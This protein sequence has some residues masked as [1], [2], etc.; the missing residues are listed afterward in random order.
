MITKL[1]RASVSNRGL[2]LLLALMLAGASVY[3][4]THIPL[5]ALP[6]VTPVQVI[7]HT[8]WTGQAPQV[9]EDQ[10][11]FPLTTAMLSV[12]KSTEVRGYSYFG[13]S[14]VFVTFQDGT[15]PY[16]ARSRV[17][18]YLSQIEGRLPE[19][20]KPA[21]G[22]DATSVG[23]VYQYALVDRT[24]QHSLAQLTSIQDWYL[25][26]ALQSVPGVAEVATMGGMVKQYQVVLD[27]QKL[28]AYDITLAKVKQA[29][30]NSS[31][32]VGG[33]VIEMAEAEYMVRATG[34]I[35]SIQDLKHIP[36]TLGKN[37]T[38]VL[39]KSV[40]NIRLGPAPRRGV[41]DLNGNGEV[42]GGIVIMRYDQNALKVIGAVK[43]KLDKLSKSL[44]PGVEIMPTYDRSTLIHH[45]VN[46][47][48]HRL[49]EEIVIVLLVCVL[50]LFH[51]RSA[52]VLVVSLPLGVLA[53]FVIMYWQGIHANI[54]SLGGLALAIGAMVDPAI[55]MIENLH[56]HFER[57]TPNWDNRW[58]IVTQAAT[59]VGPSLFFSLVI[60]A[61]SFL[62]VF[63]LQGQ[64]GRMFAPLAYTKTYA[65]AAAAGLAVTLVPVLMGYFVRGRIIPER[66]NPINRALIAAYR[67][68]IRLVLRWPR[69]VIGVAVVIVALAVIPALKLGSEFMP[70][71]REGTLLYMPITYP[72]V[73][74]GEASQILQITDKLISTVPEVKRVFGKVGRARTAT[75]T[76]PIT[77][78]DTVVMLK[79]KPQWRP[80][81]TIEKLKRKLDELVDL[82]GLSNAWV[83]PIQTRQRMAS[84]G[85]K[86][87]VGIRI[88]GP[89]LRTIERIGE[90]VQAVM[91]QVPGT[92]SAFAE[93]TASGRYI[94]VDIQRQAAARFGLTIAD[95]QGVVA[96]AVGGKTLTTTV[97]G[98]ERY[99]V[100]IRYPQTYRD[101]PESLSML[102]LVTPSGARITLGRVAELRI[103]TGPSMITTINARPTGTVYVDFADRDLGAYVADARKA[104]AAKVDLPTG[105]TITWAGR[106][107]NLQQAR[108]RL[109]VVVPA[110]LL[111]IV[112]LL[113]LNFRRFAEV[114]MIMGTLP[115]AL[116]GGFVL[117]WLLDYNLSVAAWVGFIALGGVAAELGVIM[118]LY[119]NQAWQARLERA[120]GNNAKP[121]LQDLHEAVMEG[122]ALRIRP[123]A[124][125][126]AA[127][128][129]GLLPIMIGGGTGSAIMRS[130]AAPMVGGMVTAT[131]LSLLV[132]PAVYYLWQRRLLRSSLSVH[133]PSRQG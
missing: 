69:A 61:L 72:S 85:I 46:T 33:N 91:R 93:R 88:S 4:I 121:C 115:L 11:T 113:Y 110:T 92:V 98:R 133:R 9:I 40:A 96:T 10:V 126:V 58:R 67:P 118:L 124:M 36:L 37:G 111:I 79:P 17:L 73:S 102:P 129:A 19:G 114:W 104:V 47:L 89:D 50:F 65:M 38:P 18:E 76:A 24:G 131:L 25:K 109:M 70:T 100:N 57:E 3:A 52:L 90:Q 119:L 112:L 6:D 8:S 81:M 49:V 82:P 127:I 27:P 94:V 26:Y 78:I 64:P 130:I 44:P 107:Q 83:Y 39:L 106:Y 28:R 101:S 132:L 99:P 103:E 43:A 125:T 128:I 86:T 21:L 122:T 31:Q 60:I 117:L 41:A 51:L 45:A 35:Q 120:R 14:F 53:A 75:D 84:S 48:G 77:M 1:I 55:V 32:A 62:P 42:V 13:D 5:D 56:K 108:Q 105:Y 22:P 54:L 71:L 95:A 7:I 116:V 23:W 16:W 74:I 87:P 20:V 15:D 68:A 12:P 59:E 66:A 97:E 123:I 80:G 34:Y 29:V 63:A 2:V 30:Q